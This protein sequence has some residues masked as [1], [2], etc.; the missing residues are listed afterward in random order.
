MRTERDEFRCLQMILPGAT[1]YGDKEGSPLEPSASIA[2]RTPQFHSAFSFP[3]GRED[4]LI[5][6]S[7]LGNQYTQQTLTEPRASA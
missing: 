6:I 5:L 2:L 7:A 4:T 3:G 1:S